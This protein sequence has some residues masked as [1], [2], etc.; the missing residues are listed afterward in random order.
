MVF[1]K[2]T[3][4]LQAF[5]F[6][7]IIGGC[8]LYEQEDYESEV[9]VYSQMTAL[10]PLPKV[11]LLSTYPLGEEYIENGKFDESGTVFIYLLDED[12]NRETTYPYKE[13]RQGVHTYDGSEK[14]EVLPRRTYELEVILGESN[15]TLSAFTTV[16]DTFGMVRLVRDSV[17][18]EQSEPIEYRITK[19]LYPQRQARYIL[20]ARSLDPENE[21]L[22]P[23]YK[24]SDAHPAGKALVRTSVFNQATFTSQSDDIDIRYP[25]DYIAYYGPNEI[26]IHAIDDNMLDFYTT[27][28][29]QTGNEY[30]SPGEIRNLTY[31]MEGGIGL[32][33]SK[34]SLK[35]FGYVKQ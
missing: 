32:F 10:D 35:V 15:Q 27:L 6:I 9:F 2:P 31:H 33:G 14:I 28:D 7:L 24:A 29:Q 1:Q 17:A 8:N 34:A 21:E 19:S 18:F 16:P 13:S 12:G 30:L 11:T 4:I 23:K 20:S 25:W 3:L 5:A 22:T 26:L